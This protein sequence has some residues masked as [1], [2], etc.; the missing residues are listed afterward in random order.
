MVFCHAHVVVLAPVR[1]AI[2]SSGA[3][4]ISPPLSVQSGT[5][6]IRITASELERLGYTDMATAPPDMLLKVQ[7]YLSIQSI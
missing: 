6:F 7:A 1:Q 5:V 2:L 3:L 4:Y